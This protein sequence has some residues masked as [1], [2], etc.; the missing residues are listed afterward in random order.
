MGK[1]EEDRHIKKILRE[2]M[3][4][5][6]EDVRGGSEKKSQNDRRMQCGRDRK[7]VEL[8]EGGGGGGYPKIRDAT[9]ANAR[10]ET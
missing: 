7:R 1:T 2:R 5:I 4:W 3:K 10:D 6:D 8:G 9:T